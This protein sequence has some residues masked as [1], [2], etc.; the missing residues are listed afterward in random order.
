[1]PDLADPAF[2]NLTAELVRS[3][4]TSLTQSTVQPP[5]E[6]TRVAEE[7]SRLAK[8]HGIP[9]A[10]LLTR[11][12]GAWSDAALARGDTSRTDWYRQLVMHCLEEYYKPVAE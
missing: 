5:E 3:F 2:T 6:V 1:M 12:K 9:P 8:V 11:I 4:G 7:L 10:A